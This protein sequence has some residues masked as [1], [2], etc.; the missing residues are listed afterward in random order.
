MIS[1]I[2][3]NVLHLYYNYIQCSNNI[4]LQFSSSFIFVT[5]IDFF[6]ICR[7]VCNNLNIEQNNDAHDVADLRHG[8]KIQLSTRWGMEEKG[9]TRDEQETGETTENRHDRTKDVKKLVPS[10][11]ISYHFFLV[12][13]NF[14]F[15]VPVRILLLT[16]LFWTISED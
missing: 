12:N 11:E 13:S 15:C 3:E 5:W 2:K 1:Y 8:S 9:N 6:F 14:D 10:I 16:N 4:Y 7:N